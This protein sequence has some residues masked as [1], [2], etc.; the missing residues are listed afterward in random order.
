MKSNRASGQGGALALWG[1]SQDRVIVTNNT[2]VNNEVIK[3]KD[4]MAQGGGVWLMGYGEMDNNTIANNKSADL[5]GGLFVWG[6]VATKVSN[7]TFEGNQ[8]QK[9]GAVYNDLW[10]GKLE[11]DSVKFDSNTATDGGVVYSNKIRPVYLEN[12]QFINNSADDIADVNFKNGTLDA[13]LGTDAADS[14]LGSKQDSYLFGLNGHDTLDGKGGNDYLDGGNNNDVLSGG[15]G[16]DTLV[17][18]GQNNTLFGDAGNDVFIGGT[19]QDLIEGGSGRDR[20][21]IGDDERVYYSDRNWYDHA[22]IKDFEP[23]Q[24]TIQ[25]KGRSQDYTI[26]PANSQGI[27]GTG[28]FYQGGMVALVG[29]ISTNNFSLDADYVTYGSP[30]DSSTDFKTQVAGYS[31]SVDSKPSAVSSGLEL[32]HD[33]LFSNKP[34][35]SPS[36]H[37]GLVV[38][39]TNDTWHME[40][41]GQGGGSNFKGRIV[42]ENPIEDLSYF[43]FEKNDR[44]EFVDDSRQVVNLT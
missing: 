33:S 44:V 41:T 14:I 10:D 17:G 24:D 30:I 20:F 38:W 1:Y 22:I 6:E 42:A 32:N 40:A 31:V 27:N 23:Q 15:S 36:K 25:L 9:G 2:I 5:G 8:A 29:N 4:N 37:N 11:I 18:G 39:N 3:N 35:Y 12:S 26:K 16:D 34:K 13:V 19:G 43:N 28:I 7:S 21:V